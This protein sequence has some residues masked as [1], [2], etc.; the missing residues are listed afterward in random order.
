MFWFSDSI[1]KPRD[2]RNF[3]V[4]IENSD[5]EETEMKFLE[6]LWGELGM[7]REKIEKPLN[8]NKKMKRRVVRAKRDLLLLI[9]VLLLK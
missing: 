1:S 2:L 3:K 7:L 8:D 9:M 5:G 4:G 6:S